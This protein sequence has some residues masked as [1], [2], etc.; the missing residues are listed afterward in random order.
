MVVVTVVF[1]G[2]ETVVVVVVVV[3][4]TTGL[5]YVTLPV[6]PLG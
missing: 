2:V 3:V 6:E 4:V 1:A 5:V